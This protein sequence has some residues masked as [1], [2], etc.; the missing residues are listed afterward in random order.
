MSEALPR[1]CPRCQC[2]VFQAVGTPGSQDQ[3]MVCSNCGETV[4]RAPHPISTIAEM[5][6]LL[7]EA[8]EKD[9]T[10]GT[11]PKPE[12]ISEMAERV[13]QA[14]LKQGGDRLRAWAC[15]VEATSAMGRLTPRPVRIYHATDAVDLSG[16][17]CT[18]APWLD[19]PTAFSNAIGAHL[20]LQVHPEQKAC[21]CSLSHQGPCPSPRVAMTCGQCGRSVEPSPCQVCLNCGDAF[22]DGSTNHCQKCRLKLRSMEIASLRA[23]ADKANADRMQAVEDRVAAERARDQAEAAATEAVKRCTEQNTALRKMESEGH[24]NCPAPD[25]VKQLEAQ[26]AEWEAEAK[27]ATVRAEEA[28]AELTLL[29]KACVGDL[30]GLDPNGETVALSARRFV[31]GMEERNRL[32]LH[33]KQ[34]E[35]Q[36]AELTRERENWKAEA[37]R[38]ASKL[39][40][41]RR[42]LETP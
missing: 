29:R 33:A 26:V 25:R 18:R 19:E 8:A 22:H 41:I 31:D 3:R 16:F 14:S 20:S 13:K 21:C 38:L 11:P 35:A 24:R 6:S 1:P 12:T 36:V 34:L 9:P 7:R 4:W 5:N 15:P 28:V 23:R 17:G 2:T 10:M 30:A 27:S 40:S 32:R 37:D 39:V 42:Q